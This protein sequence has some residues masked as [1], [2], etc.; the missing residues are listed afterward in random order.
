MFITGKFLYSQYRNKQE[1]TERTEDLFLYRGIFIKCVFVR[2]IFDCT[3]NSIIVF[4][5]R[6]TGGPRPNPVHGAPHGVSAA[7]VIQF[8][9]F[10]TK[11]WGL[12][13]LF[14][15]G[16]FLYSHYRNK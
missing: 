10:Q 15:T 8:K 13:N 9:I 2:T 4:S 12:S 11:R 1:K 7:L 5:L 6:A 3:S 16:K 14:V